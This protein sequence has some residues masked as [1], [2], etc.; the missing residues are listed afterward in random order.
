MPSEIWRTLAQFPNYEVSNQGRVK[1]KRNGYIYIFRTNSAGYYRVSLLLPNGSA[2]S[3][4]AHQLVATAFIPNPEGKG[5]VNHINGIRNDNKVENL[6]WVTRAEN[7]AK[8]INKGRPGRIRRV[9]QCT[10]DDGTEI[11][12]WASIKEAS[13]CLGIA[14]GN[15]SSACA[16]RLASVGGYKWKYFE[17]M[18]PGE[19]WRDLTINGRTISVSSYGRVKITTS[20]VTY[21]DNREYAAVNVDGKNYR[22][23]RLV[24]MAFK[25]IDNFAEFVVNHIDGNKRNNRVENLEWTTH[26][27][28][29]IHAQRF[30]KSTRHGRKVC[31]MDTEGR[32]FAVFGSVKEASEATG[33]C[34]GNIS[35]V[36]SG[37]RPLAGEF[38]WKYA[39]S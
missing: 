18:L 32:T 36:C 21:G 23:N 11:R 19:E 6:E 26:R 16:G 10:H 28:N 15:I 20:L 39:G 27:G 14:R 31:Q 34:K 5:Y 35:L 24:C 12:V 9:V 25:P 2:K 33:A 29:R 30:R 17:E 7:N 8:I 37:K 1:V 13:D 38:R 3:V 4:L 22:V